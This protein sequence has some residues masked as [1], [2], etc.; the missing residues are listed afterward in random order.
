MGVGKC[1]VHEWEWDDDEVVGCM[2]CVPP[3]E[4]DDVWEATYFPSAGLKQTVERHTDCDA[5]EFLKMVAEDAVTASRRAWDFYEA[6]AAKQAVAKPVEVTPIPE[7]FVQL[8]L[9]QEDLVQL[10]TICS[11]YKNT[12]PHLS[13][14]SQR[15]AAHVIERSRGY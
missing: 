2:R 10:A 11:Y 8:N 15:I 5:V 4:R 3:L 6:A 9:S 14:R 1:L 7:G 12:N 13:P